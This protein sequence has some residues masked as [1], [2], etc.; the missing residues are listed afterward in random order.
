MMA[1]GAM[2]RP[3]ITIVSTR[4]TAMP[5]PAAARPLGAQAG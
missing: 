1:T 5:I 2:S 4:T 3:A